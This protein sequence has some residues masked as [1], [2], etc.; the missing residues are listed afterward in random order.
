M[1]AVPSKTTRLIKSMTTVLTETTRVIRS[2]ACACRS[3]CV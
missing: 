1:T 3:Q 2:V